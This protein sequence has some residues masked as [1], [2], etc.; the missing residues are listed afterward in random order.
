MSDSKENSATADVYAGDAAMS[1]QQENQPQAVFAY[2]IDAD[3]EP[4]VLARVANLLNLANLAPIS[5]SLRRESSEIVIISVEIGPLRRVTAEMIRR[6]LAQ[7]TCVN[8][9]ALVHVPLLA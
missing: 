6:K 7:L 4:D 2:T 1:D 9:V 5:V 3:A 8:N